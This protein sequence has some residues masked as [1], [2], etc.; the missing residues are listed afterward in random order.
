MFNRRSLRLPITLAVLMIVLLVVLIVGWIVVAVVMSQDQPSA[1]WVTLLS[2]GITSL[3]LVL[4][5][6]VLYLV[7][8][9]KAISL[10]RRQSNFM[11]S[12]THELKSPIA[13]LKLY[14][15]T[16]SRHPV[17]E[18]Q[19]KE[20]HGIMLEDV[21]RLDHLIN[22]ILHAAQ[23]DKPAKD[24][25]V[26]LVDLSA[27]LAKIAT[28]V[29]QRYRVDESVIRQ[30]LEPCWVAANHVD[31]DL[32]FRNLLD[33]AVKYAGEPPQV[34]ISLSNLPRGK[35]M[36]RIRDNGPGIPPKFRNKVFAR[37]VR[38]GS[39]LQR[40]KP[41]T[42]LGLYIV[43]TLVARWK[44][45]VRVKDVETGQGTLFEVELAAAQPAAPGQM[46]TESSAEDSTIITAPVDTA[47]AEEIAAE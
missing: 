15:Q 1:V 41:G 44:G 21:E 2:V 20:F 16:L 7:L 10:N 5:G 38:L 43:R 6:T 45:R 40:K 27:M 29:C 8:S 42:G 12:I 9:I 25:D 33:N 34:S 36:V 30:Q 17:D 14:L 23:L 47:S 32:V 4:L 46:P 3:V 39:E 26:E 35:A 37:F 28:S 11:D 24:V 31:M 22:H 13:S 19:Q 18:A